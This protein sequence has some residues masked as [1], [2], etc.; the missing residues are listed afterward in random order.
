MG[1]LWGKPQESPAGEPERPPSQTSTQ[2]LMQ[3]LTVEQRRTVFE[4]LVANAKAEEAAVMEPPALPNLRL[5]P[6]A[7]L[8]PAS[9]SRTTWFRTPS[10]ET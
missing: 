1:Y 2:S 6:P 9:T 7:T 8:R 4:F 10:R 5:A 3:M